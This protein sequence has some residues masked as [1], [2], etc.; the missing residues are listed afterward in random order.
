MS[1]ALVALFRVDAYICSQWK[2]TTLLWSI[3]L[4]VNGEEPLYSVGP[5][6][7]FPLHL[8]SEEVYLIPFVVK[9]EVSPYNGEL[10]HTAPL[11]FLLEE[12]LL[13]L[14][15]VMK[16]SLTL[17]VSGVLP[18]FIGGYCRGAPLHCWISVVSHA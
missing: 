1:L 10:W 11:R 12:C 3:K 6:E 7:S 2:V 18:P 8:V 9:E 4:V 5:W 17:V 16:C 15:S 13:T 14:L